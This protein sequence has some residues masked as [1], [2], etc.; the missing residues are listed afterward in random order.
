MGLSRGHGRLGRAFAYRSGTPSRRPS[1]TQVRR[2][3]F[4]KARVDK[5]AFGVLRSAFYLLSPLARVSALSA[6]EAA[7]T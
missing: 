7:S 4:A 3:T 1:L 6:N 2:S 5:S